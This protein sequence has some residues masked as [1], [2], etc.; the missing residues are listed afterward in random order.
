MKIYRKILV[1]LLFLCLL[2]SLT[3]TAS[4]AQT[5]QKI[6]LQYRFSTPTVASANGVST[7]SIPGLSNMAFVEA[8][9]P[10]QSLQILLPYGTTVDACNVTYSK[11]KVVANVALPAPGEYIAISDPTVRVPASDVSADSHY[12]QGSV[13][14][15][16]GFALYDINLYPITYQNGTL[17]SVDQISLSITLKSTGV[18]TAE[19]DEMDYIP[20]IVDTE[21]LPEAY[22]CSENLDSYFRVTPT[23]QNDDL[24][25]GN[26]GIVDYIIITTDA[27]AS[28]FQPLKEYKESKGLTCDIV[29]VEA[30]Y[31]Y[32][33][34]RDKAEKIRYFIKYAYKQH[35]VKYILLGGDADADSRTPSSIVDYS[36]V[37]TRLL[38]CTLLP[39][40][41]ER[42]IASD[43]YY[44]CLGGTYDYDK[45]KKFGETTD[46]NN[47]GQVDLLP[48]VYVGRAPVTTV[49]QVKS[50]VSK[51]IAY[52]E[53]SK[54]KKALM[55]GEYLGAYS[56]SAADQVGSNAT[57]YLYGKDWK[58]EIRKGST[59]LFTT[60][61]L[62]ATYT[63]STLYDK[64][65][66]SNWTSSNIL[67]LM[68]GN[69]ELI[70]HDGH[71]N[72]TYVMR[73]YTSSLS[74]LSNTKS[75]FI[76]S[77]GCFAGGFD[78]MTANNSYITTDSMAEQFVTIANRA[79]AVA[80][81]MN[82][83]YGWFYYSDTGAYTAGGTQLFDRAFFHKFILA[84][85]TSVGVLLAKSKSMIYNLG[86]VASST[87]HRYCYYELN[88][89][90][91]PE[92]SLKTKYAL[93]GTRCSAMDERQY[94]RDMT[95]TDSTASPQTGDSSPLT[96]LLLVLAVS[97]S[98]LVF[99]LVHTRMR[100][101]HVH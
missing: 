37:P 82:S 2:L 17:R 50:F 30:I 6:S 76:F 13:Q 89:M 62:G 43:L 53:R 96:M 92:M 26:L 23:V 93:L 12:S 46:G 32:F 101:R 24:M 49:A 14:Y 83:R 79:G 34:G 52:E 19:S 56:V 11:E 84:P 3:P 39:S 36:V 71:A 78:N 18:S 68:N 42:Y 22:E 59:K 45:D 100:R 4:V 20:T 48:D 74:N 70:N 31:P 54:L 5:P 61:G 80:D 67:S 60:K 40:E 73:L 72:N 55:V 58:E 27:L 91:D 65:R 85:R 57:V 16:R 28:A 44:S 29:T 41:Y 51:T 94:V 25:L 88:L 1:G 35:R 10:M 9:L 86:Y 63:V 69:P 47:Y 38:Y 87:L 77:Q 95:G 99:L 21:F 81:V 98:G 8:E 75:F 64:D 7:V 15:V 33:R 66:S 97:L 90:G